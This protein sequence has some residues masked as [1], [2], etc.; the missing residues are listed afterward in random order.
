MIP[1]LRSG[2]Y[3]SGLGGMPFGPKGST[4]SG[5]GVGIWAPTHWRQM[6]TPKIGRAHV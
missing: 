1:T 4:G 6:P 2:G 3:F 5:L